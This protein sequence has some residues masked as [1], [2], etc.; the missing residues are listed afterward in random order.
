[1]TNASSGMEPGRAG[2]GWGRTK[3][4]VWLAQL[5]GCQAAVSSQLVCPQ[6]AWIVDEKNP[7]LD[8]D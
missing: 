8:I 6:H 4:V 3:E 7:N 1:M 2:P 5:W